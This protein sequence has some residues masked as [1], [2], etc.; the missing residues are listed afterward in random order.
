M[1]KVIIQ[2]IELDKEVLYEALVKR[3]LVPCDG[4]TYEVD[5][6]KLEKALKLMLDE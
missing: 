6:D 3:L 2:D 5:D 4:N 1:K